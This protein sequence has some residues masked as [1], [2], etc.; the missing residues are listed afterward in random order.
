MSPFV[1][2]SL[3]DMSFTSSYITEKF[4]NQITEA[5][6]KIGSN[7]RIFLQSKASEQGIG[8]VIK[9]L[10]KDDAPVRMTQ[11]DMIMVSP[12][13]RS[14]V[15][16]EMDIA[17][18]ELP[19]PV[20]SIDKTSYIYGFL[21]RGVHSPQCNILWLRENEDPDFKNFATFL[22]A[23]VSISVETFYEE[24]DA[25]GHEHFLSA[26][27]TPASGPS[28]CEFIGEVGLVAKKTRD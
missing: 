15:Y 14:K 22:A 12:I 6:R 18:S 1:F 23:R 20:T 7:L 17:D 10:L 13:I 16:E 11:I 21:S 27:T 25:A 28:R 8:P 24:E 26:A 9:L 4:F 2:S 5:A 3:S 19:Y